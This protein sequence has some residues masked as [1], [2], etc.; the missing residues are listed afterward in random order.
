MGD[1]FCSI[2]KQI[3]ETACSCGYLK[4]RVPLRRPFA[5]STTDCRI[6]TYTNCASCDKYGCFG[7]NVG[8]SIVFV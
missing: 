4:T 5:C 7:Y 2:P 8:D 3:V 1:A 6:K